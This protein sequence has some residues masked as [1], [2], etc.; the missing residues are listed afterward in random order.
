MLSNKVY[1]KNNIIKLFLKTEEKLFIINK[2]DVFHEIDIYNENLSKFIESYDNSIIK[3]MIVKELRHKNFIDLSYG[4]FDYI[5][6]TIDDKICCWGN[7]HFG[8]LGYKVRS[9]GENK[10]HKYS[11]VLN[12]LFE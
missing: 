9:S 4:Q 2:S 3:L 7:N 12:E 8:Q 11:P 1:F 6:R 5:A 10:F